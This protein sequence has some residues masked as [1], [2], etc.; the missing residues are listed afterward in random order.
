MRF[1]EIKRRNMRD[2]RGSIQEDALLGVRIKKKVKVVIGIQPVNEVKTNRSNPRCSK[3]VGE[4]EE[5]GGLKSARRRRKKSE[6]LS[7]GKIRYRRYFLCSSLKNHS[8]CAL[9]TGW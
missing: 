7:S 4:H 2:F 6:E 3:C 1:G 9:L 8:R 5:E